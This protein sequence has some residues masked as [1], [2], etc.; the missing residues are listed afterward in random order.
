MKMMSKKW[1]EHRSLPCEHFCVCGGG[2]DQ[3]EQKAT[4]AK[5]HGGKKRWL[6]VRFEN[7]EK[8]NT[9]FST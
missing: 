4:K 3:G 7:L 8:R 9:S 1:L 6:D 5:K 2:E